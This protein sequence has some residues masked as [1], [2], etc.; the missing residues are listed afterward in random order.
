MTMDMVRAQAETAAWGPPDECARRI[1]AEAELAGAGT[2]ILTCNRGAM[3]QDMFLNQIR[4]IGQ[5][6]LPRLK[7]HK[8]TR[9]QFAKGAA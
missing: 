4:R 7:A 5:E 1:I 6:V 8:V 3:P 2:V 9:V